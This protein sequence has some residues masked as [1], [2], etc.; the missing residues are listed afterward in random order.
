MRSSED[1]L[2]VLGGAA[3]AWGDS[4]FALPQLLDSERC[5]YIFLEALAEITMGILTRARQHNPELGYATDVIAMIG[6]E[7]PRIARQGVR[8]V[9]NAGGVNPR[10]AAE[11]VRAMADE[12]GVPIRVAWVEGDSLIDRIDE[13]CGLGLAEMSDGAPLTEAPLSF[14]A[15]LGA[16]PIAAALG[17]GAQLVVT[18]RCVDSALALG[19]LIHEFAWGPADLDALSQGSLAGHLL[20]CGPQS[21]GGVLTDWQD[22][23]SWHDI[24][25]PIAECRADGSFVLSKPEGTG[26]LV[27]VRT[28]AEQLLYEIGDPSAYLL[29][30]V[31]CD[32]RQVEL[33]QLGADRVGVTGAIGRPPPATLKACAQVVDGFKITALVLIAGRDAAARAERFGS[34]FLKR[35]ER[36]LKRDGYPALRGVDV[37]ILG[38]EST[39]GP[40]ARTANSREV[41]T[42]ISMH[43]DSRFCACSRRS[44]AWLFRLGRHG[45]HRRWQGP[46][47]TDSARP[48]AK[49]L[50]SARAISS[51]RPCRRHADTLP[52]A[53]CRGL[54]GAP[55]R[56]AGRLRAF[57]CRGL[58][59]ASAHCDRPRAQWRQGRRCQHRSSG[60]PSGL[61]ALASRSAQRRGRGRLACASNS[62]PGGTLRAAGYRCLELRAPRR[63]RRR[64]YLVAALRCTG[65]GLRAA[66]AGHAHSSPGSVACTRGAGCGSR[67]RGDALQGSG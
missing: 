67:S 40:Q 24:G 38:A 44:R 56:S 15:Y 14:N 31:T 58:G 54:G 28:A 27:D 49:L 8:I 43:H 55:R 32:W 50:G 20:E 60:A 16:H 52:R 63:P 25:Y 12:A 37:E 35:A 47:E 39:Y 18:G 59:R 7:L 3:G 26:G 17:A 5:D 22:V 53:P 48:A 66:T 10:A 2:V 30:D 51:N 57:F 13:L 1:P 46:S 23:A 19:P 21:T 62:R 42:K 33:E 11:A 4:A 41:V 34:E 65:Q 36:I 29:P 45:A 6:R 61:P 9:T 64:R